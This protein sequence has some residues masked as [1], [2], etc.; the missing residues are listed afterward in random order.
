MQKTIGFQSKFN[1]ALF[2][3]EWTLPQRSTIYEIIGQ[4]L[5]DR[6]MIYKIE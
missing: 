6:L 5:F 1:V 3:E 4:L 2:D